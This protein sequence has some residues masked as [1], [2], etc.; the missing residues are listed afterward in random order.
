MTKL[1][2]SMVGQLWVFVITALLQT[3]SLVLQHHLDRIQQSRGKHTSEVAVKGHAWSMGIKVVQIVQN[4]EVQEVF[5]VVDLLEGRIQ[6]AGTQQA[7][8]G[9]VLVV[10]RDL[11]PTELVD[12]GDV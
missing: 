8:P 2:H 5:A 4:L 1:E 3:T 11:E 7:A 12:V 6:Y 10:D 9:L